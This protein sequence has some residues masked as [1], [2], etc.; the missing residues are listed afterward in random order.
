MGIFGRAQLPG[1]IIYIVD[2]ESNTAK[3]GGHT[4]AFWTYPTGR[5]QPSVQ[6]HSVTNM[7]F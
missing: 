3:S 2:Q 1:V 7:K 6:G 4:C 5:H